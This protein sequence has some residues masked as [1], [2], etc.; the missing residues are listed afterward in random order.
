MF[1]GIIAYMKIKGVIPMLYVLAACGQPQEPIEPNENTGTMTLHGALAE[2]PEEVRM[3]MQILSRKISMD[4]AKILSTI[5][6]EITPVPQI[7]ECGGVKLFADGCS[8][9][10]KHGTKIEIVMGFRTRIAE[11]SLM[12]ELGHTVLRA[13]G[14]DSDSKHQDQ[15][16]WAAIGDAEAEHIEKTLQPDLPEF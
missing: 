1:S 2:H 12:H 15:A 14:C 8:R 6:L 10:N 5:E 16:F 7:M 4:V 3:A 11:T 9:H 13:A